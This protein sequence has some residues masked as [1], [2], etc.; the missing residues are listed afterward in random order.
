LF[1]CREIVMAAT[2]TTTTTTRKVDIPWLVDEWAKDF[3]KLKATRKERRLLDQ[4]F[5][6][7]EVDWK[8]VQFVHD[9]AVYEPEPPLPGAAAQSPTPNVLF[10]VDAVI[11]RSI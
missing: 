5:I 2:T 10:Q 8:R 9:D 4:G 1:I 3:F 7:R 11:T 6:S